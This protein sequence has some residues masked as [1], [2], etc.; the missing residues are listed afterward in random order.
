MNRVKLS[1]QNKLQFFKVSFVEITTKALHLD[2]RTASS[3]RQDSFIVLRF[4]SKRMA[5]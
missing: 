4:L 1:A 5:T 2:T 3:S